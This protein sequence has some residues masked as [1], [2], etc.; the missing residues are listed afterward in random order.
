MM[1]FIP[2]FVIGVVLAINGLSIFTW[3]FWIIFLLILMRDVILGVY[4]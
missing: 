1:R 4:E 3:G 2:D